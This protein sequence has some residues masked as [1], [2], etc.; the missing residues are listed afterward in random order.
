MLSRTSP[1]GTMTV[2][3]T[4]TPPRPQIALP[5]ERGA[6]SLLRRHV[7]WLV[8]IFMV[9]LSTALLLWAG[10]RPG[11][12]PYGWLIWGY[13][14]LHLTLDLGGAP[15]WK[16][17]TYVFTVPY[18]LFGH[19]ALWLWMITSVTLSLSASIF[20]GRIAY[21]LTG[22]DRGRR[23]PAIVAAVFAGAAVLGIQGYMH[24][25]LSVQSDPMIVTLCLAAIDCHLSRR[26]RWAFVLLV[27]ASLGRPEA[28]PFL[29]LY[30]IWAWREIPSMRWL[31]YVG[32]A[33]VPVLWFGIPTI[34]NGRPLIAGQLAELSP[35]Q[36]HQNKIVGTVQRFFDLHYLP[37]E[38]A[39]LVA[40]VIAVYRRNRTVLM[41]AG[42]C[43]LWLLIEIAF[44]LHGWPGV[45][46][47][48]FEAADLMAVLAAVGVGWV[49]KETPRIGRGIPHWA[50]IVLVAV[51]V[52]TLVPSAISQIRIEHRDLRH[53]RARTTVINKL[54]TTVDALGGYKR[55]LACGRPVTN[56]EYV[57]ILAWYMKLNT[58]KVG[59]RPQFELRQNYPIVMFTALRNG[60][61][62]RPFHIAAADRAACAGMNALYVPTA[63]HPGGVLVPK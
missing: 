21:R 48:M 15:S 20:G 47:Y 27:L 19:Y 44:V 36:L 22:V 35:R 60:W 30:A 42:A 49:L 6:G 7:W 40:V 24:Y 38:L 1:R 46:R 51:L 5:R 59:H 53:E 62:V 58:G 10:T 3:Q 25:I 9:A 57:S 33:L 56:V 63:R 11:Y 50:G 26:P 43:V 31:L 4:E 32:L 55:I 13:Q 28:W 14:T 39:A 61:A 45:P 52:G 23:Y 2:Q 54:Q 41:L 8:A 18:S 34:T 37:V 29:A 17:L 12:D 16:P